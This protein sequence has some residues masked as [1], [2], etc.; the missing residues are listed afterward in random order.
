MDADGGEVALHQQ[1][2]ELLGA[3]DRFHKDDH[4]VEVQ[5]VQQ[6]VQLAVFGGLVQHDVVL[7]QA[8]QGELGLVVHVD[9]HGVGHELLADGAHLGGQGGGK[10]HDLLVMRGGLEQG[11]HVRPH[12][13]VVQHLVA[14]VDDKVAHAAQ[15][16]IALLGQLL[17]AAGRADDDVRG[18]VFQHV[19]VLLDGQAAKEVGDLD[20]RHVDGE[21]L[22]LVA[23]LK[24]RV[25]G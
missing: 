11:L 5:G 18:V 13:D 23:D 8:V 1:L 16:E 4:L 21:A 19:L 2:V 10:H 24:N 17:E 14:L 20:A 12:L 7:D 3:R 6:V 22:E 15:L 25:G 9:L